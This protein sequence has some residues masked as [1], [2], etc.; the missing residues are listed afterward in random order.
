MVKPFVK[1]FKTPNA[2]YCLDINRNEFIQI[3]QCS[4]E[5]LQKVLSGSADCGKC[6]SILRTAAV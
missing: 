3:E 4:F 5:Y 1:L 6:G 2:Y